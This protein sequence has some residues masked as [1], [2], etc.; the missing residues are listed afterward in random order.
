MIS[1]LIY[2][3]SMAKAKHAVTAAKST[4]HAP[5]GSHNYTIKR[6]GT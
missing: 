1:T 3:L 4:E 5:N 2:I 6:I